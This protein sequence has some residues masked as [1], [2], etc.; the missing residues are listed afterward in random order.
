LG[1]G[2]LTPE[3]FAFPRLVMYLLSAS[4]D[5]PDLRQGRRLVAHPPCPQCPRSESR[6]WA[7]LR[8]ADG[9]MMATHTCGNGGTSPAAFRS[10]LVALALDTSRLGARRTEGLHVVMMPIG[11]LSNPTIMAALHSG[12]E[13][14][15]GRQMSSK[16]HSWNDQP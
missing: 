8:S 14:R 15:V 4:A 2:R 10:P 12:T 6:D 7:E 16:A 3:R 5:D 13:R 1:S 11:A 9:E